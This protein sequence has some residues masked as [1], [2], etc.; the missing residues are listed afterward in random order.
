MYKRLW[1][2]AAGALIISSLF[3]LGT[4]RLIYQFPEYEKLNHKW[5]HTRFGPKASW[6][7]KPNLKNAE[8]K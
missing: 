8:H 5:H 2:K 4:N 3:F 1:I 7:A 6:K